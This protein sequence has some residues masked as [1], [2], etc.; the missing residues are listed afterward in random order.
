MAFSASRIGNGHDLV[1]RLFRADHTQVSP[2]TFLGRLDTFLE[3][4]DLSVECRVTFPQRLVLPLLLGH[5]R[6]QL[7]GLTESVGGKPQLPLQRQCRC[8]QNRN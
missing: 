1:K 5:R 2:S 6:S 7:A 4:D 8:N 3:I